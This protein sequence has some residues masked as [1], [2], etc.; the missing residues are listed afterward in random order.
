MW[1]PLLLYMGGLILSPL[2]EWAFHGPSRV[3]EHQVAFE[4]AKSYQLYLYH[5]AIHLPLAWHTDNHSGATIDRIN[6]ARKALLDF[7]ESIFS[8]LGTFISL[9]GALTALIWIWPRL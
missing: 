3:R 1:T 8:S 9:I 5:C 7:G 6:N 2:I 4:A